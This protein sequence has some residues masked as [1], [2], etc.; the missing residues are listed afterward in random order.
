MCAKLTVAV[1]TSLL[2]GFSLAAN[3]TPKIQHWQAP[4]GARVY[5]VENHDLPM[6]DVAVDFPAGS[7]FDSAEKSGLAGLTHGLL[8]LGAE[9]MSE[10]DIARRLAD[11]GADR[12]SV[13]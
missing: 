10:D 8:D 6:L 1:V 7:G 4:S 2:L 3:A 11:I 12:K 9:G 5:F 13:V